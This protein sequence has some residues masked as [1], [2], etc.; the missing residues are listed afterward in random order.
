[1]IDIIILS[2]KNFSPSAYRPCGRKEEGEFSFFF[3]KYKS[4]FF[5]FYFL[6]FFLWVLKKTVGFFWV[7][8]KNRWVFSVF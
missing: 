4:F 6:F 2:E 8:L 7:S 1:L 5:F 3:S